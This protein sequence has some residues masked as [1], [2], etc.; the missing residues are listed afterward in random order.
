MDAEKEYSKACDKIEKLTNLL[1]EVIALNENNAYLIYSNVLAEQIPTSHAAHAFTNLQNANISYEII[2][3]RALWDRD[4]EANSIPAVRELLSKDV[5]KHC[6]ASVYETHANSKHPSLIKPDNSEDRF[7]II[8]TNFA[9]E[10]RTK[11]QKELS[12]II[13]LIDQITCDQR[14]QSLDNHRTKHLAHNLNQTRLEKK[15]KPKTL[16]YGDE[17]WLLNESIKIV[18][19]LYLWVNGTDFDIELSRRLARKRA[20]AFWEGISI[21]VKE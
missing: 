12:Q 4:K 5:I 9:K 8:Q 21:N 16:K 11:A 13:S 17:K 14:L 18:T 7:A 10:Q 20:V 1:L 3:I 15:S 6:Y 19:G 2:K